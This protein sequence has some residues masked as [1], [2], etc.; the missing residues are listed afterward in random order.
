MMKNTNEYIFT[1]DQQF[2]ASVTSPLK[3]SVLDGKQKSSVKKEKLDPSKDMH[4]KNLEKLAQ[5]QKDKEKEKKEEQKKKAEELKDPFTN[6]PSKKDKEK[7][8]D[9]KQKKENQMIA[10]KLKF[11]KLI[12]DLKSKGK[13]PVFNLSKDFT[14]NAQIGQGTFAIVKRCTHNKSK[15][16]IALKTYDKKLLTRKS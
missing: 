2:R 5:L 10:S 7:I 16:E 6:T 11:L 3:K 14:V 8:K 13:D 1:T 15:Y 4:L 9:E 12:E